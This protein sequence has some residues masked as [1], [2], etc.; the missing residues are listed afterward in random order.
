MVAQV[1]G[2]RVFMPTTFDET[3]VDFGVRL[4]RKQ[5][6]NNLKDCMRKIND[7]TQDSKEY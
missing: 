6:L 7:T 4:S 5:V 3:M 1:K 2:R